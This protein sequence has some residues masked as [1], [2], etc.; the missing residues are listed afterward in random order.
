[1][2]ANEPTNASQSGTETSKTL[3]MTTPSPSSINATEMPTSTE[4]IEATSTAATRTTASASSLTST[5]SIRNH[6]GRGHQPPKRRLSA[7]LIARTSRS[8]Y[9]DPSRIRSR[10]ACLDFSQGDGTRLQ[11]PPWLMVSG[12]RLEA[13]LPERRP[14]R[15]AD[16]GRAI[17]W[18]GAI[19]AAAG[20]LGLVIRPDLYILWVF[21]IAFGT[22]T[23]P[24]IA[25]S[26][27]ANSGHLD[28][29]ADRRACRSRRWSGQPRETAQRQKSGKS[30]EADFQI[31]NKK[32]LFPATL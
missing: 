5:S 18:P 32:S 9:S 21:L 23:L 4:T 30:R 7:S 8:H 1:M 13:S 26:N 25:L 2:P 14:G 6:G 3:P 24:R 27:S 11:P 20:V 22:A 31:A 15:E 28:A 19:L 12:Q 10:P 17:A 16:L 29:G